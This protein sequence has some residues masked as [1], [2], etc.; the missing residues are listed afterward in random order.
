MGGL[1]AIDT[2]LRKTEA[3]LLQPIHW[4]MVGRLTASM[5]VHGRTGFKAT[6]LIWKHFSMELRRPLL[7]FSTDHCLRA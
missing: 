4:N 1:E 3:A 2:Q 7:H 5:I 6:M